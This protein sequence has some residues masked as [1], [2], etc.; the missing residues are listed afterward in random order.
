MIKK[1]IFLMFICISAFTQSQGLKG[2]GL[3]IGKIG[4]S[5]TSGNISDVGLDRPSIPVPP[6]YRTNLIYEWYADSNVTSASGLVS[7]WKNTVDTLEERQG[8]ALNKP[9]LLTNYLNGRSVIQFDGTNSYMFNTIFPVSYYTVI[10]VYK[11]LA[12]LSTNI[13][14]GAASQYIAS[15]VTAATNGWGCYS[16]S[17]RG[18]AVD[19]ADTLWHI[20]SF[21]NAHLYSNGIEA[22]YYSTGTT[23]TMNIS[24]FGRIESGNYP[25]KGYIA[26][27]RIYNET[28]STGNRKI[29][30][31]FVNFLYKIY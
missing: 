4:L 19:L 16:T 29:A 11:A 2:T 8:T 14:L 12:T 30:E 5:K 31:D 23:S 27:I 9:T 10:I 28:S 13:I 22:S 21:Q 18:T 7:E 1:I 3:P 26:C 6:D 25:F 24:R 17:R 15:S 20:R